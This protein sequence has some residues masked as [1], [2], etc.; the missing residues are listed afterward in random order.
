MRNSVTTWRFIMWKRMAPA[1]FVSFI[2]VGAD[3]RVC[4]GQNPE[5]QTFRL[6]KVDV[7]GLQKV[8]GEKFL[9]VS[10]LRLGQSVK[11][12]DL[13]TIANKVYESGLFA[14]INYKYSWDGDNLDVTFEIVESKP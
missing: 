14:S 7:N 2:L 1:L 4:P 10:G 9:E 11:I 8:S 5:T 13:K 12:A 3:L 6:N